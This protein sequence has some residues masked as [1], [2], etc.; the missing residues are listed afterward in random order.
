MGAERTYI[1]HLTHRYSHADLEADLPP[2]V[3]P[4]YDGL[5]IDV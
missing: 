2:D 5:T 3:R 4:A 1:T